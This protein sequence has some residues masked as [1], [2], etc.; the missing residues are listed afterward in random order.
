[1]DIE[2]ALKDKDN[3]LR[4]SANNGRWLVW[5]EPFEHIGDGHTFDVG[6][7]VVYDSPPY[8]KK[9]RLVIYTQ[10]IAKALAALMGE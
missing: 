1:M 7:W 6:L 5:M 4:L 10:D 9:T 2:R 8:A 3:S